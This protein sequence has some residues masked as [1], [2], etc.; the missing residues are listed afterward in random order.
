MIT[1]GSSTMQNRRS[2]LIAAISN[3][4]LVRFWNPYDSGSTHGY[5]LDVG[6]VFF[7]LALIGED[8]R[9]N[10]FQCLRISDVR[11]LQVPDPYAGFIVSTLRKRG[12]SIRK[13]PRI[14]LDNLPVLL[15]SASRLFPLVTVHRERIEPDT[16]RIGRVIDVVKN[17]LLLL[18]IDANAVWCKKTTDILIREITRVDFGGGYEEALQLVGGDPTP[19]KSKR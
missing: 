17:R 13:K 14:A 12:Q 7:L 19:L 10:G 1:W 3:R 5:V 9:F 15:N 16:C 4:Q 18:E 11:S 8:I 6:P 2:K